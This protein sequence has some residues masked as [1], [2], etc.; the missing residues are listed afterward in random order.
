MSELA[1]LAADVAASMPYFP[2]KKLDKFYDVQGLLRHPKLFERVCDTIAD[3]SKASNI[4]KV[5]AFEARGF[6][7]TPVALKLNVP[8][9]MLRKAGKMPNT[10]SSAPYTKEYEGCDTM[11]VQRGAVNESD[12]VLLIDDLLATGGTLCSG[13]ELVKSFGASSIECCTVVE[14]T[15]LKGRQRAT[16]AGATAVWSL[17]TEE[18]DFPAADL[19]SD[20]VDDGAPH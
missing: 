6:L 12:N 1:S 5:A 9:V 7:F 14:L 17:L 20:Y 2:Y 13:I 4:T 11:C 3:R 8:F 10:V 19:P 16:D 18:A 15:F